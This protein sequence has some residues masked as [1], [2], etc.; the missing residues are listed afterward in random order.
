MGLNLSRFKTLS[1]SK[2]MSALAEQITSATTNSYSNPDDDKYWQPTVDKN[3]NG[4][5]IIRFLPAANDEG[6]EP[7]PY[8]RMWS[9]G[10]QGPS[11]KWY[12]ENCLST[13]GKDDPVNDFNNILWNS[14]AD[15][16]SPDKEQARKQKRKLAYI[17]NIYI[18]DDPAKPENNGKVFLFKF[19]AKIFAKIT[20]ALTPAKTEYEEVVKKHPFDIFNGP[21]LSLRIAKVEGYRNYDKSSF[22]ECGPLFTDET[23]IED[24]LAGIHPLQELVGADK[25]KSF[26]ELHKKLYSVL[27]LTAQNSDANLKSTAE[28]TSVDMDMSY[29]NNMGS[30]EAKEKPSKTEKA[31]PSTNDDEEDDLEFFKKLANT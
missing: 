13:I 20:D 6:D 16:N 14:S 25:F 9:H 21:N 30:E 8:V 27:G 2:S 17:G 19:G 10:F 15:K 29:L 4:F 26:E 5:A 1:G 7:T 24:A 22:G 3:G 28:E 18:V 12:I 31:A 11:G 23:K